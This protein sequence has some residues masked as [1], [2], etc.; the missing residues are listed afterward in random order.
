MTGNTRVGI[1]AITMQQPFASAMVHGKAL[2]TRRGK[3]TVFAQG[4]EWL[5]VH[6][7]SNDEHLKNKE[8]MRSVREYWPECP[9]DAE[10]KAG[11]KSILGIAHFVDGQKDAREAEKNCFFLQRYDCKKSTAWAADRA[12]PVPSGGHLEYPKGN[13]QVWHL[14]KEGFT[15]ASDL[16]VL[17]ELIENDGATKR[18]AAVKKEVKKETKS[19]NDVDEG[20]KKKKSVKREAEDDEPEVKPKKTAKTKD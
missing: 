3:P 15:N 18:V 19:E 2:F 17:S 9:S 8:L 20:T 13:L 16:T 14:Y 11:Q 10:L 12:K 1:R 6:C 5:A 4:G 7:G